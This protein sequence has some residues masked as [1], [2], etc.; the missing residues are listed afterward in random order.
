MKVI[1]KDDIEQLG[2]AGETVEVKDGYGRNYLMPRNL[3]IPAT[4]ANLNAIDEVHRQ[5]EI[6][7]RKSRRQSEI[8]KEHIE[9]LSPSIEVRVGIK[10]GLGGG[11]RWLWPQLP[12]AA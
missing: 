1:L 9:R 8:V 5:K 11:Q 2:A 6:R 3:A 4:K 10:I 7:S 12:H